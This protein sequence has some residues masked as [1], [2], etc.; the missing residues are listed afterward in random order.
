MDA[1]PDLNV[2]TGQ[3]YADEAVLYGI[4]CFD[5][6]IAMLPGLPMSLRRRVLTKSAASS[7]LAGSRDFC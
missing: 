1:C 7:V 2:L 6:Y 3:V 4:A 5:A